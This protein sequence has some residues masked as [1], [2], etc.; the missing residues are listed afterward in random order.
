MTPS[1]TA[2]NTGPLE[3]PTTAG[4]QP[5]VEVYHVWEKLQRLAQVKLAKGLYVMTVK[6]E[7][8]AGLN[9]EYYTVTRA[10]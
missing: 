6:V 5:G 2:A 1:G 3:I 7:A 10:Q 8:V 4:Y 9:I